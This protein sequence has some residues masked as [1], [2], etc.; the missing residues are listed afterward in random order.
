MNVGFKKEAE[1][2]ILFYIFWLVKKESTLMF[3]DNFLEG[4]K[5]RE[6]FKPFAVSKEIKNFT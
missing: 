4:K 2:A 1:L 5:N 3:V 6:N